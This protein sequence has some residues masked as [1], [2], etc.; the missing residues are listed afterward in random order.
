MWLN[1][2]PIAIPP[3]NTKAGYGILIFFDTS[4]NNPPNVKEKKIKNIAIAIYGTSECYDSSD[5]LF[6][7]FN[8]DICLQKKYNKKKRKIN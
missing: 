2:D 5:I 6:N 8:C 4:F 7:L 3:K 1:Y